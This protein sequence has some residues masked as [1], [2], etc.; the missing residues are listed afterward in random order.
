MYVYGL[1]TAGGGFGA[2]T[3]LHRRH[4]HP[5]DTDTEHVFRMI[6]LILFNHA[7]WSQTGRNE[8][9]KARM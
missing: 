4:R 8:T 5:G 2:A 3:G 6:P 1:R 9:R 7:G